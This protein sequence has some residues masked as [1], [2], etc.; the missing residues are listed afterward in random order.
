[1]SAGFDSP[2][3]LISHAKEDLSNVIAT[4]KEVFRR[5]G[6]EQIIDREPETGHKRY[7]IRFAGKVPAR[8]SYDINNILN[9]LRHSLDQGLVASVEALTGKRS[10]T[11]YFPFR[12]SKSDLGSWFLSKEFSA[13]PADLY[14]LLQSFEPYPRGAGYAGGNDLLCAIAKIVGPNK[15][16]VTIKAALNL[17][18]SFKADTLRSTGRVYMMGMPPIWDMANNEMVLATVADDCELH[19]D[20]KFEFYVAFGD[21]GPLFREPVIPVL[22]EFASI[23]ERIVLGLEAETSRILKNRTS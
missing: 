5:G 22:N 6:H 1:M 2:K 8:V 7:K 14:P 10:G 13:V 23:A 4:S 18:P 16:Q 21:P 11:I 3:S 9:N 17:G 15:H 12:T 20:L 19:Y